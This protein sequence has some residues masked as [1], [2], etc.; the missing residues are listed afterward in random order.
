MVTEFFS[1]GVVNL[2]S[3]RTRMRLGSLFNGNVV[4][5]KSPSL[6][7]FNKFLSALEVTW[8]LADVD[9]LVSI[10]AVVGV[11]ITSFD[12]A[13]SVFDFVMS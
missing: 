11:M 1:V 12:T 5:F 8:M 10:A 3:G 2:A 13:P 6:M 9:G 4:F 7:T